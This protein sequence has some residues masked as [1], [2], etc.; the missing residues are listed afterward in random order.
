M[1]QLHFDS[2]TGQNKIGENRQIRIEKSVVKS[3]RK[4]YN[5]KG[6]FFAGALLGKE[7]GKINLQI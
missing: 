1:V 3:L 6:E 5:T 4:R 2:G 7:D